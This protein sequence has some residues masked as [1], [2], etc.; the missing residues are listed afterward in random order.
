M[1]TAMDDFESLFP[2]FPSIARSAVK[3]ECAVPYERPPKLASQ[4]SY[5]EDNVLSIGQT[6]TSS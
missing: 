5:E 6:P 2:K 1:L 3:I 4:G